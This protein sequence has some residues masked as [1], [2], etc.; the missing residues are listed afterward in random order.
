MAGA[1]IVRL[2]PS[3]CFFLEIQFWMNRLEIGGVF[4]HL[5]VNRPVVI[6]GAVLKITV[7]VETGSSSLS[8]GTTFLLYFPLPR[9]I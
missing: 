5:D 2:S 9:L 6:P 1:D 7:A 3:L 8:C 4:V